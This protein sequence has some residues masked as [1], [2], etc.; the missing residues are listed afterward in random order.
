MREAKKRVQ[1]VT[2]GR[3]RAHDDVHADRPQRRGVAG[4]ETR[5]ALRQLRGGQL[6]QGLAGERAA[7]AHF[8]ALLQV[9][10]EVVFDVNIKI[11]VSRS[12]GLR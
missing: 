12:C 6:L 11:V 4:A 7:I 8:E 2:E 1:G 5:R 9:E 3:E 10:Y